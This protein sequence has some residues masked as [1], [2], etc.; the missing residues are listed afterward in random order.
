MYLETPTNNSSFSHVKSKTEIR[1]VNVRGLSEEV[2][3]VT[4]IHNM[5]LLEKRQSK[6]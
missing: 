1:L 6:S 2:S 3:V 5:K 4:E